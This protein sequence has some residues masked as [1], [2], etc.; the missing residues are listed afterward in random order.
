MLLGIL[1]INFSS[2]EL[3]D[4]RLFEYRG[5]LIFK[6]VKMLSPIALVLLHY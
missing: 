1:I 2:T 5:Y 3:L 6:I 4:A